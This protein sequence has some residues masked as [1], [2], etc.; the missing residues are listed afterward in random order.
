MLRSRTLVPTSCATS[1]NGL[2]LGTIDCRRGC[3][4]NEHH[5]LDRVKWISDSHELLGDRVS[6]EED[7]VDSGGELGGAVV[8]LELFRAEEWLEVF[9]EVAAAIA[10]GRVERVDQVS[11]LEVVS[12]FREDQLEV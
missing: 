10:N 1:A 3:D 2:S 11:P 9:F 12:G 6:F 7:H 8:E 4:G 5:D